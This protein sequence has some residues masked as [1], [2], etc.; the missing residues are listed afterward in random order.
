MNRLKSESHLRMTRAVLDSSSW[1]RLNSSPSSILP[2]SCRMACFSSTLPTP[3]FFVSYV[4]SMPNHNSWF[5]DQI[6][7]MISYNTVLCK[8]AKDWIRRVEQWPYC[9]H[10]WWWAF[11]A[12]RDPCLPVWLSGRLFH[13]AGRK[14]W[15]PS[16]LLPCK[17]FGYSSTDYLT[18]WFDERWIENYLANKQSSLFSW[19]P[20]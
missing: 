15:H 20:K 4:C 6:L 11:P 10:I 13:N 5:N 7:M 9:H 2:S 14:R 12:L 17:T 18:T 1:L 19:T 8:R 16:W 3:F